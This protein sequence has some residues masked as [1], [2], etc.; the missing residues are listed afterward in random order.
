MPNPA[1]KESVA[2]L[3]KDDNYLIGALLALYNCQTFDEQNS[4]TTKHQ[5]NIG[6]NALDA[7]ILSDITK[8]YLKRAFLSPKQ[9]IFVRKT[10][11]KYSGQISQLEIRPIKDNGNNQTQ[12]SQIKKEVVDKD[13]F[14]KITFPFSHETLAE[15]KQLE[16]RWW[17]REGKYWGCPP[18]PCHV[19]RLKELGFEIDRKILNQYEKETAP[20]QEIKLNGF[21]K[22]LYEFQNIGLSFI[23]SKNGRA[24]LGDEMGLGKTI[25]ALAWLYHKKAFPAVIVVPASLK[26]NWK[27]EIGACGLKVPVQI[28]SGKTA[29]PIDYN[30]KILIINYDILESWI[31]EL[32]KLDPKTLIID[33][34]HYTKNIKAKRTKAIRQ[35]AKGI[36]NII[37]LT[38]TPIVNRPAEFFPTLNLLRPDIFSNFWAFTKEYC[39]RTQKTI[40]KKGKDGIPR[41][42]TIWDFSGCSNTEKLHRLV[43]ETVMIRRLKSEVLPDLPAK[44]RSIIAIAKVSDEYRKAEE[45]FIGWLKE[46]KGEKTAK[47]A[48]F[49]EALVKIEK[50]KQ[51]AVEDKL[52]S[53]I[54]WIKDF[55]ESGE[56]LVVFAT[57]K[58]VINK[59]VKTFKE[60]AVK[61]D[62][63]VTGEKRNE[64]VEKF[65]GDNSIRLFIGNMKAAGIGLNLHTACSN[66]CFLELG[67]TP[68]DH[69]QA[70]D[71]VHRIG[72]EA[73]SINIWY[74]LTSGSVEENIIGLIDN[75]RQ[76]LSA[77]LD[78]KEADSDSILSELLNKIEEKK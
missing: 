54:D 35:L 36:D 12:K 37:A 59:L 43:T 32:Q 62:G 3:L 17:N 56:K 14:L 77:V 65:N 51:L 22:P 23:E 60:E 39:G 24:L 7:P 1:K 29:E 47:K 66:V 76:V 15:V 4:E 34:A 5:N 11:L 6:F 25:Q 64:A 68:A 73:E 33:E 50:L 78:G 61:V 27:K 2:D 58:N 21:G 55:L 20:P 67:W 48:L 13:G 45:D 28:L 53:S 42:I 26:I 30:Q 18:L 38:G 70:E 40:W 10:M 71:R 52:K 8:F 46:K 74:L 75:K 9:I 63:S 16:G 19:K 44:T 31:D 57:H 72:Q 49:A 41:P 69:D